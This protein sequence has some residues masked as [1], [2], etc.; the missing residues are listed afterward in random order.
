MKVTPHVAQKQRSAID[1]RSTRHE[2]TRSFNGHASAW[3]KH[4]VG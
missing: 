3:R 2:G 1:G 4:S